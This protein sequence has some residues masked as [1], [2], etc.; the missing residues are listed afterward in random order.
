MSTRILIAVLVLAASGF[1]QGTTEVPAPAA[2]AIHYPLLTHADL[3]TY[4]PLARYAHISGTVEIQIT[5]EKGA[6][7]DAQAK[8]GTSPL[9]SNPSL[10][11]VKTWQFQPGDRATFT[12]T[13]VYQLENNKKPLPE[14][15]NPK[16]ELDLPRLVKI[17]ARP[18]KPT[19]DDCGAQGHGGTG[20]IAVIDPATGDLH[21]QI[22]VAATANAKQ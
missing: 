9:L 21:L 2:G 16:V 19:C 11:N 13:Y 7:I 14:N 5:V 10:A 1:S 18:F 15:E 17:T 6:V 3:P 8:S 20:T 4:P 22:P 12:V